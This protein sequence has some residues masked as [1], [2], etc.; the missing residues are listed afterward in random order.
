MEKNNIKLSEIDLNQNYQGYLWWSNQPKP[1]VYNMEPL[2]GWRE[3][4][5]PFIIEGQL[6]DDSNKKSYSIRF[7][8]GEYVVLCFDLNSLTGLEYI[9]KEY[10]SNRLDGVNK[11]YFEEFWKTINDDL[12]EGMDVLQPAETVFVGFNWMED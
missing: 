9:K 11:I 5:N 10:L 8:D 2:P 3:S 12:C 4:K 7:T 6:Y 1:K